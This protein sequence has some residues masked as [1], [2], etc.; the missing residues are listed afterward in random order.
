MGRDMRAGMLAL[1]M[2]A[3]LGLAGCQLLGPES[4]STGRLNYNNVI[5]ETAKE[6]VFENIVRVHKREPT[7]F[8]DVTEVDATVTAQASVGGSIAGIGGKAPATEGATAGLTY[9]ESPVVRY[10]PL[11]GQPLVQQ[12]S[13]PV[14][15][16]S[17][18]YLFDSDWAVP[19]VLQ[20]TVDRMTPRF[21]DYG[22]ALNAIIALDNYDAL[23]IAAYPSSA[24][25]IF[26]A[27]KDGKKTGGGAADTGAGAASIT[28]LPNDALVL[29]L[30]A[31]RPGRG[32]QA[33]AN[34]A[35]AQATARSIL[36][37]WIR[38]LRIYEGTQ[39]DTEGLEKLCPDANARDACLARLDAQVSGMDAKAVA[40]TLH[41]LPGSIELRTRPLPPA[42]MASGA[43][44]YDIAA[45]ILRTRS[46]LG[47]L[48]AGAEYA[49]SLIRFVSAGRYQAL[50]AASWNAP[51]CANTN[52]RDYYTVL[53]DA[54]DADSAAVV[55]RIKSGDCDMA[56]M[57]ASQPLDMNDTHA[58]SQ[59]L[60]LAGARAFILVAE[61]PP[62]PDAYVSY[63]EGSRSYYIAG[64]D[65]VSKL[66]F[67]LLSQLL[68]MQA[69]ASPGASSTATISISPH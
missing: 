62:P 6:Q 12:V 37:L 19:A 49:G 20:L 21:S 3:S 28:S 48:K 15:A 58:V 55:A 11:L 53:P 66:N 32:A 31:E 36:H 29:Y 63:S 61:G 44:G 60:M 30:E 25:T 59:E 65:A 9:S 4:I 35:D 33:V 27:H 54:V 5:Q 47:V 10:F 69:V 50:R 14:T 13:S 2:G 17:L 8:V 24:L 57:R 40:A 39:R 23:V 68:T 26:E 45:P 67:A 41:A 7:L 52:V 1:A 43:S 18:A 34:D 64:D 38:L 42:V 51:H 56:T 16:D 22:A 46:A